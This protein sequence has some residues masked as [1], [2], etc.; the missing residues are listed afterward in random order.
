MKSTKNSYYKLLGYGVF[1]LS[2]S[3]PHEVF[4]EGFRPPSVS[5]IM[6]ACGAP[7]EEVTISGYGFGAMNL[8]ISVSGAG[9][10]ILEATGHDALF[11]IPAEINPGMTKVIA[12]NPGGQTGEIDFQVKGTEICG[13]NFDDDCDGSVD[14]IDACPSEAV[15]LDTSPSSQAFALNKKKNIATSLGFAPPSGSSYTVNVSQTITPNNGLSASP[16]INGLSYTKSSKFSTVLAQELTPSVEG[17]YTIITTATIAQTGQATTTFAKVRVASDIQSEVKVFSPLASPNTLSVNSSEPVLLTASV[18]G[19]GQQFISDV[20]VRDLDSLATYS[21]SDNGLNGDLQADDFVFSGQF[22]IS[23]DGKGSG[24]CFNILAVAVVNG[25]ETESEPRKLCLTK[26]PVGFKII[27][28]DEIEQ[29]GFTTSF[30]PTVSKDIINIK[31]GDS[32]TEEQI[33]QIISGIGGEIIGSRPLFGDYQ[34][35]LLTTPGSLTELVWIVANLQENPEIIAADLTYYGNMLQSLSSSDPYLGDQYYLSKI[36]VDEA[37]YIAR[38]NK[39]VAVVDSGVDLDHSDLVGQIIN[40]KD[41]VDGDMLPDDLNGHG[42]HVAGIIGAK[43]D[44]NLGISGVVWNSK[45][46]AVRVLNAFGN[47]PYYNALADGI[48]FSA[49]A[50]AKIINVSGGFTADAKSAGLLCGLKESLGIIPEGNC[51]EEVKAAITT[52]CQAVEYITSSGGMV[53]AASGNSGGIDKHYPA[54]CPTAIAVAAT[55]SNDARASFSQYGPWVDIAAPGEEI[56]STFPA[57]F[58]CNRC[59]FDYDYFFA[60][61]TSQASPIVAGAASVVWARSPELTASEVEE[62]LK[63]SAKPLPGA[64]VGAGRIDVF[65]AVFDGSFEDKN[66]RLWDYDGTVI[67]VLN[68]GDITPQDLDR[69]GYASTGPAGT[70]TSGTLTQRFQVQEGVSAIPISFK[71]AFISEEYPEWVGTQFN[72]SLTIKLKAPNGSVTTL[73]NET[74][75]SAQFSPI[76]G[77]DFPGGDST[78]GWTGWKSVSMEVPISAG[79][80]E[81][82]IQL[83]DAGDS[84]YDT[85]LLIDRIKFDTN[86]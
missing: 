25:I 38:G 9:A 6:P 43:T 42:T 85:V 63:K 52:V 78:V 67:T 12:T 49:E 54:A 32:T 10:E 76:S 50:G 55:D 79:Q 56:L 41:F 28:E 20:F 33:D 46:L 3:F 65:E 75:N 24:D 36:R 7:G 14:E 21:L 82:E 81:Y 68:L 64:Q 4:A 72:D 60:N 19:K 77:I 45:I 8:D 26:Y 22:T 23:T 57:Q 29:N 51:L 11:V 35:K 5:S 84:I 39:L 18:A 16:N 53:V 58:T 27:S 1:A 34:I 40:G 62:R 74:I 69:M 48:T 47:A 73:A 83:E 31:V 44:N 80:G 61:G 66:M 30:G 13:N 15:T 71:Y 86:N 70:Q 59:I 17:E 2:F 37:W